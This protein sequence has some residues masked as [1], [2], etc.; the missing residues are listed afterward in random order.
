MAPR[1]Q[2][3]CISEMKAINDDS[4]DE[5][6]DIEPFLNHTRRRRS[7]RSWLRLLLPWTAHATAIAICSFLLLSASSS[8]HQKRDSCTRKLNAYCAILIQLTQILLTD[9]NSSANPR[10]RERRRLP[11]NQIQILP[12]VQISI[13][14]STHA[15]SRAGLAGHHAMYEDA[16]STV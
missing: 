7:S 8:K 12:V 10:R 16:S 5:D 9:I 11:R 13:Q 1:D 15:R 6:D 3:T 14:R 4:P 2:F